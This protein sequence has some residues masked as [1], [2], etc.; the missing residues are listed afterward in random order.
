MRQLSHTE[1]DRCTILPNYGMTVDPRTK[2]IQN[3]L[4]IHFVLQ[5]TLNR[6]CVAYN[7][8][9]EAF[10]ICIYRKC[11][12]QRTPKNPEAVTLKSELNTDVKP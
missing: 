9:K 5:C 10:H 3:K 4:F 1:T 6:S 12:H 2:L 8:W 7:A 11:S